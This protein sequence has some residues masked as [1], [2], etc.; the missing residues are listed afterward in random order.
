MLAQHSDGSSNR[1]WCQGSRIL[2][3]QHF[4]HRVRTIP[5]HL[6]PL[7]PP[8][9]NNPTPKTVGSPLAHACHCVGAATGASHGDMP[10]RIPGKS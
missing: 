1:G 7:N 5:H 8:S 9:R 10:T 3:M 4:S 6:L 2:E